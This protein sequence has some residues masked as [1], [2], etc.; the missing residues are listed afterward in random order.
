MFGWD[1]FRQVAYLDAVATVSTM[2]CFKLHFK[3]WIFCSCA[4]EVGAL[5]QT[6]SNVV[7]SILS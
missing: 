2:M 3:T 5:L 7:L 6:F 4:A 1:L